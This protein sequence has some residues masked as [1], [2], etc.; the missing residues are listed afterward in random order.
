MVVVRPNERCIGSLLE[1]HA[2]LNVAQ[3]MPL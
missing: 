1:V 3:G 2:C